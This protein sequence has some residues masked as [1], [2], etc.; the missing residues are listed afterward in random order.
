MHKRVPFYMTRGGLL[1]ALIAATFAPQAFA[2]P[3]AGKIDFAFGKVVAT[4]ADGAPRPLIKGA[5]VYSGDSITTGDGRVQIRFTD[6]AY[7]ALQ[8]NTVFKVDQYAF[9][10]KQDG[11]E[12]GSF[13]LVKGGLR[14]IS[15]LIGKVNKQN[16]E[17]RTPTATIGIRGTAYS[18]NQTD[19]GLIV[20]VARGLVSVSNQGGNVTIGSGQSVLV[21]T[22]NS[23]PEMTDEKAAAIQQSQNQQAQQE[24]QQQNQQQPPTEN[25]AAAGEQRAPDGTPLALANL[26]PISGPDYYVGS[27]AGYSTNGSEPSNATFSGNSLISY[28]DGGATM[29][30]ASAAQVRDA[31]WD[32]MIGWG[33]WTGVVTTS[34][35]EGSSDSPSYAENGGLSYIVGKTAPAAALAN[36]NGTTV[37]YDLVGATR[38][39]TKPSE[40]SPVTLGTFGPTSGSSK[41]YVSVNFSTS[42]SMTIHATVTDTAAG[43]NYNLANLGSMGIGNQPTFSASGSASGGTSGYFQG[44][45]VGGN[46]ERL[47]IA[48]SLQ[49][50]GKTTTGT[51]AFAAGVSTPLSPP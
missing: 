7:M 44:A 2:I 49:N 1:S 15:G 8:P 21:R 34:S 4:G 38:P 28:T 50:S 20:T 27:V 9:D 5:E 6:G 39:S 45:F 14:T 29:S 35:D 12:K 10:G 19:D 18:A 41:A 42:N 30:V 31:G 46:A 43:V 37:T 40:G 24:E 22:P 51:A 11:K 36:R 48:Y 26:G 16:Y 47:G 13:S 25:V 33:R 17:V 3:V 23:N 32:G